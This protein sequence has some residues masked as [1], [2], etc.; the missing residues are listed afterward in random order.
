MATTARLAGITAAALCGSLLVPTA[1]AASSLSDPP[2][3]VA[4]A[5]DHTDCGHHRGGVAALRREAAELSAQRTAV[6]AALA[7]A[8]NQLAAA[9]ATAETL[10]AQ[11]TALRQR[12]SDIIGQLTLTDLI[13]RS[14]R[15]AMSSI[16]PNS[17]DAGSRLAELEA[18]LAQNAARRA[19]LVLELT[20]GQE[21]ATATA[22]LEAQQQVVAGLTAT[23]AADTQQLAAIDDRLAAIAVALSH[24]RC[25]PPNG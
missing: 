13:D 6:A 5:D 19:A 24:D 10:Q 20:T 11:V 17:P 9:K 4:Q 15:F 22:E 12:D 2:A 14:I 7:D 16:D 8:E 18:A 1:A 25:D 21:L 23:V 3:A